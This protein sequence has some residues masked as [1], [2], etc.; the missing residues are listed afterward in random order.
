MM[1]KPGKQCRDNLQVWKN[2]MQLCIDGERSVERPDVTTKDINHEVTEA[3]R[4]SVVINGMLTQL[5]K[6]LTHTELGRQ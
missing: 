4:L 1:S 3:K 2:K 5:G 6:V